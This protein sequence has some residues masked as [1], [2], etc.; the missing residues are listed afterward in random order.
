MASDG[1]PGTGMLEIVGSNPPQFVSCPSQVRVA[2]HQFWPPQMEVIRR[3]Y[4]DEEVIRVVSNVS[5]PTSSR[6]MM[7]MGIGYSALVRQQAEKGLSITSVER[8]TKP[9]IDYN[10]A[11]MQRAIDRTTVA[12][13]SAVSAI[14]AEY[15]ALVATL[16][17]DYSAK[18]GITQP[19]VVSEMLT[20]AQRA[21]A[22]ANA[23]VLHHT[24]A[25]RAAAAMRELALKMGSV[26]SPHKTTKHH[27][28][29]TVGTRSTRN[30]AVSTVVL[31]LFI[32]SLW[33]PAAWSA[34][35]EVG[36]YECRTPS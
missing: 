22:Q 11:D 30:K 6:V 1:T 7:R 21:R 27:E 29:K 3:E 5:A 36:M 31:L 33:G 20:A 32:A 10:R 17:S 4:D 25:L 16:G 26:R 24:D 18:P 23:Q 15:I 8:L 35:R 34:S 9:Q 12:G 2:A 28:G 19:R 14:E 13:V